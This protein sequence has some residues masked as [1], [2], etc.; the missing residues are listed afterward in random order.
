MNARDLTRATAP[1]VVDEE[2][3][4]PPPCL[5]INPLSF[6]ASR[7][8]AAKAEA[9]GRA[10]GAEVVMLRSPAMLTATIETVLARRQQKVL[11]MAGDGTV[12]AVLD[13][14]ASL[15]AGSWIPD[16]LVLPGG[17]TNLTAADL[18][19]GQAAMP[20]LE[21][22]LRLVREGHWDAS[23]IERPTM[24]VSHGDAAPRYGFFIAGAVIDCAIRG[25]HAYRREGRGI[26][27]T[28]DLSVPWYLLPQ[29]WRRL[30]GRSTL[31]CPDMVIDA[32]GLGR[33][34]APVGVL[35]VSTLHHQ[36]GLFNPYAARGQGDVRLLATAQG[37]QGFWRR[38]PRIL[39]GRF[40]PAM[41]LA[42]GYL[43]G[44][45]DRLEITG[46]SHGSLDGEVF[47][48]DP[49]VP[50]VITSGPRLRFFCP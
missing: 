14:L 32:R 48:A 45:C 27:G 30:W 24:R 42:H 22:A 18:T 31:K 44:R 3:S 13:Q 25:C 10:A 38:L 34:A 1:A 11:V 28:L 41:D 35:L 47:D 9:M 21:R 50:V 33:L 23:V 46:L 12:H 43:T 17:R 49:T 39:I 15:P 20:L 19:P 5:I 26:F 40:T 2:R 6:R 16:L 4:P 8:L 37:A 7:G 36:K 29:G